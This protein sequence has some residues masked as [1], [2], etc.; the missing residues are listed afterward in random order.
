MSI[1]GDIVLD[2]YSLTFANGQ[3]LDLEPYEADSEGDWAGS[4]Q[5]V[6]GFI[7]KIDPPTDP[8]LLH[9][10]TACAISWSPMWWSG[11]RGRVS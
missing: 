1:T 8:K 4:G 5:E 9:G 7:Y 10:K 6:Q 11:R 2:D 3:S